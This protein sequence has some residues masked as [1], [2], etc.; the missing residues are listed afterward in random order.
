[1]V[2]V[3]NAGLGLFDPQRNAIAIQWN[4]MGLAIANAAKHK[5]LGQLS[6][7]LASPAVIEPRVLIFAW[8]SHS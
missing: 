6:V 8:P 2:L 1:V 4:S 7:G 5:L 3:T